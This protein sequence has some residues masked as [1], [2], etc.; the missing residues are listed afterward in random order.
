MREKFMRMAIKEAMRAAEEDEV[1]VGAVVVMNGK[2]LCRA[3]NRKEARNN[4]VFHAEIEAIT[5]A[6]K[7]LNN[8]YL[9]ECELYVTL[10]PC[11]MCAGAVIN[12]RIKKVY[13]GA[14][15]PRFGCCGSL[16]NLVADKRFNHTAEVEGGILAEE[17]GAILTEYFRKKRKEK[18][19]E[20]K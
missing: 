12:S 10:E 1:P 9:D 11:A 7:K 8:W 14:Y 15:D 13:F 16:Y 5:K 20:A 4:A 2:V 17:C 6:A 18:Q 19:S 3:H